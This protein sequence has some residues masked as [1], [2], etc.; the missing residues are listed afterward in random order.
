MHQSDLQSAGG[1]RSLREGES[2]EFRMGVT[3]A[4]APRAAYRRH[5]AADRG[6][7]RD[8]LVR[9]GSP[10]PGPRPAQGGGRHRPGWR[11]GAGAP[12]PPLGL[13]GLQPRV[14]LMRAPLCVPQGAPR[15]GDRPR[16]ER[17]ERG[18]RAPR[19]PRLPRPPRGEG[20]APRPERAPRPPRAE[21][22]ARAPRERAPRARAFKAEPAGES[23]GLQLVVLNLPWS[24]TD[25]VLK[26]RT[27]THLR[28]SG[29]PHRRP[30]KQPHTLLVLPERASQRA[31]T[32]TR[33]DNEGTPRAAAAAPPSPCPGRLLTRF[34][35]RSCALWTA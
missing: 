15:K 32:H 34:V 19:E 8:V 24:T 9:G 18:E 4:G 5:N 1:F 14:L 10:V 25:T 20:E 13:A 7:R 33:A 17:G 21:G 11:G 12:A 16:G 26:A 6:A 2:V 22:E 30:R 28:G 27:Q 29:A 31:V 23:S 3:D 35:R